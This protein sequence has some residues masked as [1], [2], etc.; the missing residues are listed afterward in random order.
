MAGGKNE[1][2][3]ALISIIIVFIPIMAKIAYPPILG[4]FILKT[5]VLATFNRDSMKYIAIIM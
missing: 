1:K 4:L 3:T 2:P 5:A